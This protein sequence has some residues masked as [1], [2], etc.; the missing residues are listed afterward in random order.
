M[1][2]F[3]ANILAAAAAGGK[4]S[5][6]SLGFMVLIFVIF[7]FLLIRPQQKKEKTR[8]RQI[9][10]LTKGDKI[11]TAGGLVCIVSEIKD[12]III[13]KIGK[14]TK[15]EIMKNSVQQVMQK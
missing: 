13:A 5:L 9:A 4:S 15:I 8:Q 7:Y 14:E 10:A 12:D 11:V 2:T 1:Y 6:I 3:N